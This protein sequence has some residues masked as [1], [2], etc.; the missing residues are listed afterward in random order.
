[1]SWIP[2]RSYSGVGP[3]TQDDLAGIVSTLGTHT[4]QIAT[5]D[6]QNATQDSN[7]ATEHTKNDEQDA[8]LA[9]HETRISDAESVYTDFGK[10]LDLSTG[11]VN[12]NVLTFSSATG[13]YRGAPGGGTLAAL[14][15]VQ[16]A[17]PAARQ[18]LVH[19]G[20]KWANRALVV[21]TVLGGD[22]SDVLVNNV[23]L[24]DQQVLTWSAGGAA[25]TNGS[26]P[27]STRQLSD[28]STAVPTNGQILQYDTPTSKYV[29][30]SFTTT[31]TI[32]TAT[33]YVGTGTIAGGDTLVWVAGSTNKFTNSTLLTTQGSAIASLQGTVSQ[34]AAINGT[35]PSLNNSVTSSYRYAA[36]SLTT[37][38]TN[39]VA[40]TDVLY[41][42]AYRDN[43]GAFDVPWTNLASVAL[44]TGVYYGAGGGVLMWKGANPV[45]GT[46]F[47]P[48]VGTPLRI[49]FGLS[50]VVT[51]DA[52]ASL[53]LNCDYPQ[54]SFTRYQWWGSNSASYMAEA[55]TSSPTGTLLFDSGT[56]AQWSGLRS[57]TPLNV[58]PFQ[59]FALI[60]LTL[61][62]SNNGHLL[63]CGLRSAPGGLT[64][65]SVTGGE[66]AVTRDATATGA[67]IVAKTTASTN[68]AGESIRW[69]LGRLG[70]WELYNRLLPTV[71]DVGVLR[72]GGWR[73][74]AGADLRELSFVND[75]WQASTNTIPTT[76]AKQGFSVRTSVQGSKNYLIIRPA[77]A[78]GLCVALNMDATANGDN[79]VV[80]F[81]NTASSATA[82]D[83]V[84]VVRQNGDLFLGGAVTASQSGL[85][86]TLNPY[87]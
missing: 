51:L 68:S 16:I 69:D 39:N 40:I 29:P 47:N 44:M 24:A 55:T 71:T 33:D 86:G 12:N 30:T 15:D 87:T 70:L 5:L 83:V 62:T 80:L 17:T 58:G 53:L 10:R 79:A 64:G 7:I 50:S 60:A 34:L 43:S 57:D 13:K 28:V 42:W 6:A 1:M 18:A 65:K 20:T 19:N 11:L 63:Y 38:A 32:R 81:K 77:G 74:Q 23:T 4:S 85:M 27:R 46:G 2:G 73:L 25:W 9:D 76:I 41:P 21:G 67:V 35:N 54:Y 59:Y 37:A 66:L 72:V 14:G 49:N 56:L 8:K 78:V 61:G 26:V 52:S 3:A 45:G 84:A 31:S 22:L 48:G 82:G 36:G 75:G